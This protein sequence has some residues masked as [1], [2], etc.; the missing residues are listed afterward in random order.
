MAR[1]QPHPTPVLLDFGEFE[2]D[3][4]NACLSRN[5]EA[6]ALA[7]TPFLLLCVLAR[8]PGSLV[9]KDALLDAVWGHRFVS[10]SVLKTAISDLRKVLGDDP[11]HPRFIET[12]SRR[13]YRFIAVSSSASSIPPTSPAVKATGTRP[14]PSFIGRI[15]E[16]TRLQRAWERAGGG[17]RAVVWLAGEPGIGKTTL[18]EHFLASLGGI[19]CARGHCV[20]HYGT[21]EPYLP[22]LEAL[23]D[24]CR[25]DP[26]LPAL[27]RDVAPTWLLQLPWLS[28]A[29]EREALR[30]E[31]AGVG[32]DRMLREMGELL[33][34]YTEQRPL[35]LV[36]EDLHWSDRATVQL[37]DYIA[38]RRGRARL[39]WLSSFRLAEVVALDH[40]LSSLRHELR[41]QRLCEEVVLDP[42]SETEIADYVA[43]RSASLARDEAFVRA[44]H[45]RTDG[46]PLF[47]SS[48][49]S[50]VMDAKEDETTIEARLADLAVPDNLA[51]IIDHYIAKLG[52]EQR[53]LLCAAAV[54][55][56]D[57][58]VETVSLALERNLSSVI[59]ACEELMREQVWLTQ[60]RALD[61]DEAVEP[62]YSFRHALFR[63]VLYDR[64]PRS[65]RID[66]HGRVG[67]ALERERSAGVPVAASELA[68]HFDRARL[69][70]IA[71][72]YYAEAAEAAL[73]HFSPDLC[74]SLTERALLLLMQ[75][76][77]GTE[78]D[79][80]EITLATLQGVSAFHMFGVGS[81]AKGAFE[82]AYTLLADVPEHPMRGRLL[83]GFGYLLGL[84]GDYSQAL[85][86]AERAEALSLN[87]NDAE[88]MLAACIV[89]A[90]VHH[91][92]GRTKTTRRWLE[93]ALAIAEPLGI[94]TNEIFAADPQVMLHGMLAI[95]LV[96]SG[97]V[98]QG[99]THM[100]QARTRAQALRQPMTWLVATWQE[101][102]I[103]V[104][105]GNPERVAALAD[106]MQ[107]L[108][109]EYSL[110]LGRTACRWW[111][112][113]ADARNGAPHDG[114]R[115]IREAYEEHTGLGMRSGD[116]EVLGYAAEALLLAGDY[117]AA[118]IQLQEALRVGE[119]LGERVFL[120]QL[121]LLE[122]AIARTQGRPDAGSVAVRRA[123]EEARVQEAPWLELLARV[124]LSEHHEATAED[125]QALST[126]IDQ[127]P[128][129]DGTELAK[130]AHSLLQS[131]KS[132]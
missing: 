118:H 122:A 65:L 52:P 87:A 24:L 47:V 35:L 126:L 33:D 73:L 27:L 130:H 57:F 58:R 1:P 10:D 68:M 85:E 98:E 83:H 43:L 90:E 71:L 37:I 29:Q 120:P 17:Q 114:Y 109:D 46:V 82:R 66:L 101:V 110:A 50:E 97:L 104:R 16:V 80:L 9:S 19:A 99:R 105:L 49:I 117:D 121:L 132:T 18:I 12:V 78:R 38:R 115:H 2:L 127:L 7:P 34:R 84:R 20:E 95:E 89:Q 79:T 59:G 15:D 39:M 106:D 60:S 44:L 100:Q 6:V 96:R 30:R 86:V 76:P 31:L 36:T 62:P 40:P 21:G 116:S 8:Q 112:G 23:A 108:V 75:A 32:P 107:N 28:T 11:R 81:E 25:S 102:L 128:E 54:C 70:M 129:I 74:I 64:T 4:A 42:F 3:E 123:V 55:G 111:R 93:R 67:T 63:Q 94:G 13:G 119:E 131:A 45:E 61:V 14:S 26:S 92:Q 69:P 5:R 125:H 103:E 77:E 22:V 48:I 124:E 113:W 51:A 88:L 56:A 72:R 53:T 41:L 91:L